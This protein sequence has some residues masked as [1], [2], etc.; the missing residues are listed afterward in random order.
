MNERDAQLLDEIFAD[1]DSENESSSSE[2]DS[3]QY[4]EDLSSESDDNSLPGPSNARHPACRGGIRGH[5]QPRVRVRGGR[6]GG[7]G[8][9]Q[10]PTRP[11]KQN[12]PNFRAGW[13]ETADFVPQPPLFSGTPGP[14]RDFSGLSPAEMFMLFFTT[15]VW[16]LIVME[17]NRYACQSLHD[18]PEKAAKWAR[19]PVDEAEI[20]AFVALLLAMGISRFP[21]YHM[22]WSTMDMLRNSFYSSIMSRNRFSAILRYLHLSNNTGRQA[23]PNKLRKL[24]PFLDL[25]LPSFLAVYKPSQNLSPDESM[26]RFKGR[27]SFVQYM[28]KKPVKW[29]MKAFSLNESSTG[30]TCAWKLYIGREEQNEPAPNNPAV[31]AE[32]QHPTAIYVSGYAVLHLIEGL[33][34]KGYVIYCDNYYSSPSLFAKLTELGFGCCGT[35]KYVTNGISS[36][37]NPKV[38]KMKKGDPPAFYEKAGQLCVVWFDKKPVTVLTTVG[39]CDVTAKRIR[40]R[41]TETGFRN[42]V[43]PKAIEDYN[44]N[45]GG[46]DLAD[47]FFQYYSHTHRSVKWWKRV[48]FHMLEVC[49]VNASTIYD[50]IPTNSSLT[51]LKFRQAVIQGLLEGWDRDHTRR[52]RR[53]S[54]EDLPGRLTKRGHLMA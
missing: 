39:N 14:T 46:T 47:Q 22:Y 12:K 48:F 11:R 44:K 52:G 17:T 20:K 43:K 26:L 32:L 28:P 1:S 10:A 53:S 42:I 23:V 25:V 21:Q 54:R 41:L 34:N 49:L 15:A 50:S 27:L 24:Q 40:S 6:R 7:G 3:S 37:A 5:G 18:S 45:M 9:R 51:K 38:H 8:D 36:D 35:V 16:D 4:S 33:E 19:N 2:E 31:N 29:G 13:K 30:Y